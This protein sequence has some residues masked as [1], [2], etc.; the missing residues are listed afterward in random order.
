MAKCYASLAQLKDAGYLN[1]TGTDYDTTLLR[2]LENASEGIDHLC[3]RHFDC[4]EGTIYCDG[5]GRTLIPAEDILSLSSVK[6]D[7]DGDGTYETTLTSTDYI[8]YPINASTGLWP[9]L[10]LKLTLSSTCGG[11]A[12][13]I[14]AGVQLT[15]VFGHGDGS[16]AT[17]YTATGATATVA[18]TT[19]TL[20]S[21]SGEGYI[22]VGNTIRVESEQMY[23]LAVSTNGD[24]TATVTR[25]V[26]GTTSATHSAEAVSVYKYAGPV[27]ESTLLLATNWWK[28]RENPTV[29]KAGN[30]ITGEY[31]ISEDIEKI[32]TK[33]L[34]HHIKRKLV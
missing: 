29:F 3:F 19:G 7:M 15:G 12:S 23:V 30:T 13:G 4:I 11:F 32:L 28:Q 34:G 5:S 25:G 26:N 9:K 1:I 10:Y 21:L 6:L 14:L 24:K 22:Q 20:L 31:E 33:R 18:S 27:V 16:S 2:M 8:L 17:P